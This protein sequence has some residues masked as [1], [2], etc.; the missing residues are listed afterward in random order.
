M[1][2]SHFSAF[3]ATLILLVVSGCSVPQRIHAD[4]DEISFFRA[5]ESSR[6]RKGKKEIVIANGILRLKTPIILDERD[7]G[8]TVRGSGNTTISGGIPLHFTAVPGKPY[9]AAK[10][11][12]GLPEPQLVSSESANI[13]IAV[14]PHDGMLTYQET[15]DMIYLGWQYGRWNRPEKDFELG[16]ITVNIAELP[17][18]DP[19]D[20][21]IY[22]PHE[23]DA[24][25]VRVAS[26]D[27]ATG[28]VRFAN[29]LKNPAGSFGKNTYQIRNIEAGL[30]PGKWMYHRASREVFY[31]PKEN[32]NIASVRLTASVADQ[33][34]KISNVQ[35]VSV[36]S[37]TFSHCNASNGNDPDCALN[38]V[39]RISRALEVSNCRD[40][41]FSDVTVSHCY[42]NGIFAA[43]TPVNHSIRVLN[44][45]I[46]S[47]GM[48]GISIIATGESGV[49]DCELSDI[50]NSGIVGRAFRGSHFFISHNK[51]HGTGY[52][53]LTLHAVPDR[54]KKPFDVAIEHN[55]ISNVMQK[56][57]VQ[58]GAGIYV[59][60]A[61]DWRIDY[62]TVR[63]TPTSGLRH[64][65]YFDET[66]HHCVAVGNRISSFFPVMVHMS[67]GITF[68]NCQFDFTDTMKFDLVQADHVALER[69]RISAPE[70]LFSAP[71]DGLKCVDCAIRGKVVEKVKKHDFSFA[72]D[73]CDVLRCMQIPT[74]K[75]ERKLP[76]RIVCLGDSITADGTFAG[77]LQLY[78]SC[79]YPKEKI[80][81]FNSGIGGDSAE[82]GFRRLE[83]DVLSRN[84]DMVIVCF[85]MNDV[86]RDLYK[87]QHPVN[88]KEAQARERGFQSY[89][90]NMKKIVDA[91]TANGIE[92]VVMAP[93][94]YDEYGTR[95][96]PDQKYEYCNCIGLEKLAAHSYNTYAPKYLFPMSRTMLCRLYA[97][98][99]E[100][101]VAKDRVHPDRRGHW[102]IANEIAKTVFRD[103]P[104]QEPIPF[105][106]TQE[107]VDFAKI[108]EGRKYPGNYHFSPMD[109]LI[110]N[111]TL[112]GETVEL[113]KKLAA[114]LAADGLLRHLDFYD[115]ILHKKGL[116]PDDI[117]RVDPVLD[118]FAQRWH[119]TFDLKTYRKNRHI[120]DQLRQNAEIAKKEYFILLE[121]FSLPAR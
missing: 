61:T 75:K 115:D 36:E 14:Y 9:W 106:M 31:Y 38:A 17:A 110:A 7:T 90:V 29:K 120:R 32:E 18:F 52:C 79:R 6:K 12:D 40:V 37:V 69:C 113:R 42:G 11:P 97:W 16:Q 116:D 119:L 71:A 112:N 72:M 1:K 55:D 43:A 80:E 98:F 30:Q 56:P 4:A 84:P 28:L 81:I 91:L 85:G 70:I 66:S 107:M 105:P 2:K 33:L 64:G 83:R 94:P 76:H 48:N 67:A 47:V 111:G 87:T 35:N 103:L 19:A 86:G 22:V 104:A 46:F 10:I 68:Q 39:D 5:L 45:R 13:P 8:L 62:N 49:K 109:T 100:L 41:T 74:K 3:L 25:L 99:P 114:W 73:E 88:E 27:R 101:Q 78:L 23:W 20:A 54:S 89:C 92:V 118:D 96:A 108:G 95:P 26:V 21:E 50:G 117:T 51:I 53:G 34:L 93:F 15:T 121:K 82:G 57:E 77:E 63:D 60:G 58:D 44:S 24:S 59:C 65:I 102:V